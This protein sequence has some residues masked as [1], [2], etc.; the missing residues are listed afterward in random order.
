M[1]MQ[2][3]NSVEWQIQTSQTW[4]LLIPIV[5][6]GKKSMQR[7]V[8]DYFKETSEFIYFFLSNNTDSSQ[9]I[10]EA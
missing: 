1:L 10:K 7:N 9:V 6:W 5:Y 4:V 8:S 3:V 2:I